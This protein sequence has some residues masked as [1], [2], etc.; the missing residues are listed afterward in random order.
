MNHIH[1]AWQTSNIQ[2]QSIQTLARWVFFIRYFATGEIIQACRDVCFGRKIEGD[3]KIFVVGKNGGDVKT[4][5]PF[6][7]QGDDF[8]LGRSAIEIGLLEAI[9]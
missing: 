6:E 8:T 5:F 2:N 3:R 7:I 1:P 4:I 9:I